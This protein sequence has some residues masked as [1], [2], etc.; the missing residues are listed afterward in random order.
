MSEPERQPAGLSAG[1]ATFHHSGMR[2][3][4]IGLAIVVVLYASVA[5]AAWIWQERFVWQPP[6]GGA[7]AASGA[8][9]LSYTAEDGQRLTAW[10]IGNPALARGILIAFH[11][12]AELAAWNVPW[13]E[14]TV[15][16]TGWAVLLPEYRGYGGLDGTPSYRGS[17]SD[18][19]ATYRLVR[20]QLGVDSA[21]IVFYGHSLGTAVAAE[22]AAEHAPA[23]LVLDAPFTSAR[24]MARAVVTP[25]VAVLWPIIGRV[26][27]DTRARVETL[28]APVSVAHGDR[29]AVIPVAMGRAVH[30][31]ARVKGELLIVPGAGH[32]DLVAVGGDAYWA[33][34]KRALHAN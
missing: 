3:F 18:A 21:R 25:A 9:R 5:A 20:E 8:Q 12:N 1:A 7:D 4:R 15:R 23:A 17:R 24:D 33:W 19:R 22:L 28:N 34:L 31:A 2:E 11:G 29:D 6:P 32:G 10:L 26:A 13:A 30:A 16:R 27:F 14:E